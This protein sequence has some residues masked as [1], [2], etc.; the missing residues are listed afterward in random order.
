[1]GG[2]IPNEKII[3]SRRDKFQL[4][5]MGSYPNEIIILSRGD[6]EKKVAPTPQRAN[7]VVSSW[8]ISIEKKVAPTPPR[9]NLVVS[10]WQTPIT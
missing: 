9:E 7:L 8:Q 5:K 1:M 2:T 4:N 3:L 10:S 6:I